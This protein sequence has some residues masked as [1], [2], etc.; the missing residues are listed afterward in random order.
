M[1]CTNLELTPGVGEQS[2]R[3]DLDPGSLIIERDVE[4]AKEADLTEGD[5]DRLLTVRFQRW[6]Q[7][8]DLRDGPS[9]RLLSLPELEADILAIEAFGLLTSCATESSGF[10][11]IEL[12]PEVSGHIHRY[13]RLVRRPNRANPI[14]CSSPQAPRPGSEPRD[15]RS[16][17][18]DGPGWV[19][20]RKDGTETS[21]PE[22]PGGDLE[23]GIVLASRGRG[24]FGLLQRF[25]RTDDPQ[26]I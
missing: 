6:V 2:I 18:R 17:E 8:G 26:A 14:T 13:R 12:D 5:G 22:S 19:R 4:V 9:V 24:R 11:R 21:P 25:P 3:P 23:H 15:A 20:R 7:E 1:G 10:A 16:W